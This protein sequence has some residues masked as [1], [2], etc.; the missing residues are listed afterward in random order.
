[1]L[2]VQCLLM[3]NG[4]TTSNKFL[5]LNLLWL[6]RMN[7]PVNVFHNWKRWCVLGPGYCK[8]IRK[9]RHLTLDSRLTALSVYPNHSK[10]F[11]RNIY[12][13]L[14]YVSSEK[15]ECICAL[16]EIIL[17]S[18]KESYLN[19]T[20]TFPH[21]YFSKCSA[22]TLFS[23]CIGLVKGVEGLQRVEESGLAAYNYNL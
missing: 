2:A 15:L 10:M 4:N 3:E 5:C 1:M 7:K 23:C 13:N 16:F 19:V 11:A 6:A 17:G 9:Q 14:S 8:Y 18:W 22:V 12:T 21:G 20:T